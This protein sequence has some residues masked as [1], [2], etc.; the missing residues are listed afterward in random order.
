MIKA[1]GNFR[2][3]NGDAVRAACISGLGITISSTWS[4]YKHLKSGEL[5]E[6][7]KNTPL[8]NNTA[9]WAV[10]PSSRLL[11]PKVRAFIDYFADYYG[12]PPYW[13]RLK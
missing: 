10:Y 3:D 11:A 2:T 8:V 6:I 9:I 5:I 7:L 12:E 1:K 4:V 13:E